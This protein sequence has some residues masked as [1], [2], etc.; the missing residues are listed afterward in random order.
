MMF[1]M[2]IG[3]I[4]FWLKIIIFVYDS[5]KQKHFSPQIVIYF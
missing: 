4:D 1:S 5:E 3:E 2:R